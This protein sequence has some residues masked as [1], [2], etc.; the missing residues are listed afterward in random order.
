M[1]E[2][3]EIPRV[4]DRI[5]V[6]SAPAAMSRQIAAVTAYRA[7]IVTY[8]DA[9]PRGEA[10]ERMRR[11]ARVVNGMPS[12]PADRRAALREQLDALS[13]ARDALREEVRRFVRELRAHREPPER[14]LVAVKQGVLRGDAAGLP[15]GEMERLA[16]DAAQWAIAAYYE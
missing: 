8:L 2:G 12:D 16:S 9:A 11:S 4:P 1:K 6:P 14:V 10:E 7:A 13:R 15:F 5:T 3:A